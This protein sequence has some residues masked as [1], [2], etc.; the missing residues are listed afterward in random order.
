MLSA[1]VLVLLL[2][3]RNNQAGA[4]AIDM[5]DVSTC[6]LA[7]ITAQQ[8]KVTMAAFCLRRDYDPPKQP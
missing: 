8:D 4:V 7:R 3:T 5:P 6:N 1:Y 2:A